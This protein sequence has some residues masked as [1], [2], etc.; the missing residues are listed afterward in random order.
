MRRTE[1]AGW[2][3]STYVLVLALGVLLAPLSDAAPARPVAGQPATVSLSGDWAFGGA[4]LINQ[5]TTQEG[6]TESEAG[7][8]AWTDLLAERSTGPWSVEL[9]IDRGMLATFEY[10]LCTPT[11]T[12]PSYELSASLTGREWA[13]EFLNLSTTAPLLVGGSSQ[14][15]IGVQNV[16][17]VANGSVDTVS[18]VQGSAVPTSSQVQQAES[19]AA[20]ALEFGGALGLFPAAPGPLATWSSSG[21][22][23]ASGGWSR[24]VVSDLQ[25][26]SVPS[27][28]SMQH[29]Q[30]PSSIPLTVRGANAGPVGLTGGPTTS[31]LS[32]QLN[33]TFRLLDGLVFDPTASSLFLPS[34]AALPVPALGE[35]G[36]LLDYASSSGAHLG[37]LASESWFAPSV[38]P[39][40]GAAAPTSGSPPSSLGPA[41]WPVQ[42]QTESP[43]VAWALLHSE[44]FV[45]VAP[46]SPTSVVAPALVVAGIPSTYLLLAVGAI[47]VAV[48]A[49]VRRHPKRAGADPVAP[50]VAPP[51]SVVPPAAR[52]EP[53][54]GGSDELPLR[55]P[56]DDL[57]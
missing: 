9:Q 19:S 54:R 18:E 34:S 24:S 7:S 20:F 50:S 30:L 14:T 25:G 40:A 26:S 21:T 6:W 46:S 51:L 29:T 33:A 44:G 32:L 11:C 17:V 13:V 45:S 35:N 55:D 36:S 15:G 12:L 8:Y 43:S 28:S 42:A 23:A 1:L 52:P 37:L 39:P 22:A 48:V 4:Q 53:P 16:S 27:S 5:S 47:G 38:A 10:T 57:L 56:F 3:S 31:S 41:V 49:A 2:H